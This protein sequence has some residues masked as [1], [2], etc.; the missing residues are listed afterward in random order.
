MSDSILPVKRIS[1]AI[2]RCGRMKFGIGLANY[3]LSFTK[4]FAEIAF[5]ESRLP[6]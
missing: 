6:S 1:T 4:R 3:R 2:Y 5:S